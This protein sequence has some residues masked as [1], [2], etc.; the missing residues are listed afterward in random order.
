MSDVEFRMPSL[1]ADMDVGTLVEWL[2]KPG[3]RVTR[4]QVV[5][6]VETQKGAI[7]VE[8]FDEGEIVELLLQPVVE[9]PVGTAL[10]IYRKPGDESAKAPPATSAPV[11]PATP[12]AAIAPQPTSAPVAA[13]RGAVKAAPRARKLA[14]QLGVDLAQVV[15]SGP[16]GSITGDDV[17]RAAAARTKGPPSGMRQA[18][19]AAMTR[20]KH[21]IPHY[22]LLHTLDLDP[23]L[24]W[25]E[26]RNRERP[27]AA[28][29]LP[30]VLLV[31]AVALALLDHRQ[32]SGHVR[33]GTF[34]PGAGIN[35][36]LAVSLRDGGLVNPALH[37]AD[38]G[39]LDELMARI[40]D[41]GQRARS[42]GLRASELS[43]ATITVT[44][45][46]ERGVDAVLP[47]IH[48]PQVAIVGFGSMRVRPWVDD[49]RIVPRRLVE[50]SLAADHR[51]SDGHAGARFL[52]QID[53]LL[54]TPEAL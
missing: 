16:D 1:G 3:D 49:G 26:A 15:G 50:A 10:A 17:E 35:V 31:R 30:I 22:Y 43:A 19:A 27:I 52:A 40:A 12:V 14:E 25:L 34:V 44:S 42:G 2:V 9:V 32:L 13:P 24:V 11:L 28:R 8:I 21:E 37:D 38:R 36:G 23:A 46:G 39:T 53:R 47:I 20:S 45:L 33:D 54:H 48:P 51:V 4:G 18:I 5:A 41:V 7:D 29:L 6:V